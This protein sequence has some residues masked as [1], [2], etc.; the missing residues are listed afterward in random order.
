MDASRFVRGLLADQ[1]DPQQPQYVQ[2]ND[3]P[4]RIYGLL[5][6]LLPDPYKAAGDAVKQYQ[7]GDVLGAFETMFGGMPTTGALKAKAAPSI[8]SLSGGRDTAAIGRARDERFWHPI[9]TT[10]LIT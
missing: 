3:F 2:A 9:S 8:A 6:Q 10:K 1:E 4:A 7:G 5:D